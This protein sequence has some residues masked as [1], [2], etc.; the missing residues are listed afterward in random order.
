MSLS[1]DAVYV[2]SLARRPDRLEAFWCRLPSDWPLPSPTVFEAVDG[3]LEERPRWWHGTPGSWGCYRSHRQVLADAAGAGLERILILE[4]D[5][6]FAPDCTAR[7]SSL[8]VPADC[9]MLYLGGQHLATPQ[10]GPPGLVVGRNVNRTHAY[11]VF[12]RTALETILEHLRPDPALWR[13]R[14]HIDHHYGILHRNGRIRAY[15]CQPWLCGQAGG[16]SDVGK[17]AATER[18]WRRS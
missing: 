13:S 12:G 4:D 1:V 3:H 18:W 17:S 15:A 5:A 8:E 6:T 16:Q 2:I 7:A 10:P 9:Q 11:A 14:H